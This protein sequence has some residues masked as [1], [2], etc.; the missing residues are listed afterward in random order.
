MTELQKVLFEMVFSFLTLKIID[1]QHKVLIAC[2]IF[3]ELWYR[4]LFGCILVIVIK[5]SS[6]GSW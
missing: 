6:L 1:V 5:I 3:N 2:C 4:S